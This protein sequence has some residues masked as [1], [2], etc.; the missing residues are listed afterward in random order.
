V[1]N[2]AHAEHEQLFLAA[3][4][5]LGETYGE[6]IFYVE[7]D[8]VFTLQRRLREAVDELGDDSRV[9]NDYPMLPGAR[10]SLSADLV[11]LAPDGRVSVAAEFKYEPCHNRLD[12]L[13]NKLPVTVWADIVKDTVRCADFVAA[14][15]ADVA[16]AI[17]IDEGGYL[18]RRDLSVWADRRRWS[19]QPHHHHPVDV[20]IHRQPPA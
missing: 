3:L 18:G 15:K 19:G 17:C 7:R 9:Y 10:R 13:K 1:V 16:Y 4:V 8:V 11:L 20:L 12:V 2:H 6:R 14:G 5:W